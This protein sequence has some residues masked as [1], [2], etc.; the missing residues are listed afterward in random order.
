MRPEDPLL[1]AEAYKEIC[2]LQRRIE[3]LKAQAEYLYRTNFA[4]RAS[5]DEAY[6]EVA[7]AFHPN[8]R[9]RKCE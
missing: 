2:L 7:C 5:V 9:S 4:W 1:S 8:N 3:Y 6:S